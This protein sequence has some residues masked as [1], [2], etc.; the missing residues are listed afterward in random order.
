MNKQNKAGSGNQAD[1][2]GD[3]KTPG[4]NPGGISGP[5]RFWNKVSESML[6]LTKKILDP[7]NMFVVFAFVSFITT[8]I[9]VLNYLAEEGDSDGLVY[10]L[11]Y[12][13]FV[14][15]FVFMMTRF[16]VWALETWMLPTK[17]TLRVVLFFVWM[18][19]FTISVSFSF[20]FF[21]ERMSS[22]TTAYNES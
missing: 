19:L 22:K 14:P 3:S 10:W 13:F 12:W 1:F 16:M 18:G 8:T 9:G 2:T 5:G 15:G 6:I 20:A 21:W 7:S 4:R 11:T 17:V